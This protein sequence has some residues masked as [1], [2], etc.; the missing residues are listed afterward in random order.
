M[1]GKR[2]GLGWTWGQ[3]YF[4]VLKRVGFWV[5]WV[6]CLRGKGCFPALKSERDAEGRQTL[7]PFLPC[8]LPQD[9]PFRQRIAEVF[10]EDGEGNMTLEDFLDMFSVMSEMAPR[11]LKA[12]YAFRIYGEWHQ[13]VQASSSSLEPPRSPSAARRSVSLSWNHQGKPELVPL[14]WLAVALASWKEGSKTR[15]DVTGIVLRGEQQDHGAT[16]RW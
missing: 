3:G 6:G 11:D 13:G 2:E 1:L 14:C 10:S 9:N 5:A 12:Y 8:L 15:A 7:Y 16:R 4:P